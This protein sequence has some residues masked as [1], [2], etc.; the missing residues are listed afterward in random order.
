MVLFW[1]CCKALLKKDPSSPIGV[2]TI[3]RWNFPNW[4]HTKWFWFGGQNLFDQKWLKTLCLD[5]EKIWLT[6]RQLY[7]NYGIIKLILAFFSLVLFKFP[8]WET[9][10]GQSHHMSF[11]MFGWKFSRNEEWNVLI[12]SKFSWS[13]MSCTILRRFLTNILF[14]YTCLTLRTAKTLCHVTDP[15]IMMY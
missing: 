15:Y 9:R 4:C 8:L 7:Y 12:L 3:A 1:K 10:S 11:A 2:Q 14:I 6:N 13:L 5:F